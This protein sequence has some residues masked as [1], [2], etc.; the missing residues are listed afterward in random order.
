M[1]KKTMLLAMAVGALAFAAP[2]VASADQ[3]TYNGAPIAQD[4][5]V[6][7]EYEG[8]LSFTLPTAIVPVH[9]TFG[10]DVTTTL[11]VEGTEDETGHALMT[12]FAPTTSTCVGTGA[13][14]G[15]KVKAD[16][17]NPPWTVDINAT[18]LTVTG[19]MKIVNAYEGCL[20]GIMGSELSFVNPTVETTNG[21]NGISTL[22]LNALAEN[23]FTH[24]IGSLH[25]E[26]GGRLG[27]DY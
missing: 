4:D 5:V 21:A 24:T 17:S 1:L 13:F 19:T 6:Q 23:G 10:C 14:A 16:S 22:T 12:Q 3:W 15:C 26:T 27:I 9:T 20:T 18:D 7:D 8:F 25:T 2:A 11:Q